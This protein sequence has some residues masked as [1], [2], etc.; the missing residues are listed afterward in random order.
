TGQV[1]STVI[2]KERRGEYLGDTVQVIPHITDAIKL[3]MRSQ[4][5]DDVD[6]VITEIGGTVGHIESQP[7]PEAAR[8]GLQDA[9]RDNVLLGPFIAPSQQ[10]K[11]KTTQQRAAWWGSIG[12]QPE[13]VLLRPNRELPA[14][15]KSKMSSMRDVD[16]YAVVTCADDAS[17][18]EIP[19][20]LQGE[21]LEV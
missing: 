3:S 13:G 4:A 20:V 1:Y 14:W 7:F 2:A 17:I 5:H 12:V 21:G 9:E 6:V 16:P 11:A 8:Q 18:S 10:Q 15:V 19:L